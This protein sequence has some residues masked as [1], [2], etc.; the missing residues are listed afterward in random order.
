MLEIVIPLC[1]YGDGWKKAKVPDVHFSSSEHSSKGDD[2]FMCEII[3][4]PIGFV[5]TEASGDEV[6][7]KE[8]VSRLILNSGLEQALDGVESFSHLFI[9]YWLHEISR[10]ADLRMKTRPRG[11]RDMP[12]MGLFATRTPQRPNP[13]GLTLVELLRIEGCVLTVRGLDAYD[14]TPILDI[15][16]YDKWDVPENSRMPD[17]WWRLEQERRA[18]KS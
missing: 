18:V 11:R 12:L 13:I 5:E 9:L 6:R 7:N 17:W 2:E 8:N 15:K 14:G 3:L 4:K 1:T 16:P 10:N